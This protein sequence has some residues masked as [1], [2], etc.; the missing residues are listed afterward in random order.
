M[1]FLHDRI[2]RAQI[3]DGLVYW[4]FIPA[5]VIFGGMSADLLLKLPSV[6]K[7]GALS[8]LS[9]ILVLSGVGIIQKATKDL[10]S[11]GGGTPNPL[12]P[13]KR[14]VVEGSYG[15]CRHPMFFGYDLAALGVVLLLRSWGML[16][17]AYPVFV[18]ME[19]RFLRDEEKKLEKRFGEQFTAYRKRVPLLFPYGRR[20]RKA[21]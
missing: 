10:A 2:V 3:K 19:Y 12:R 21:S 8:L 14:L 6:P 18:L 1:T 13:P 5:A 7:H 15:F 11:Y 20:E 17:V 16:F 9:L 4:I